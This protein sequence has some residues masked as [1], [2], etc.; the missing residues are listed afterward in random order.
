[1]EIKTLTH[2]A[3]KWTRV[4]PGRSEDY[5]QGISN[6]RRDWATEAAA[7]AQNWKEGLDK[8]ASQGLYGKGIQRAGSSKWKDKSLKKGPQRFSEGV[9]LAGGDY[10]KAL[11]PFHEALA[12]T[13]LG[14]RFPRRDP[15][16]LARVKTV[17]DALVLAKTGQ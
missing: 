17:V 12:R 6:P 15:R 7:G 11:A 10:Q 1:M 2:I 14:P 4:T 8:A 13:D 5:K 9:Y 3:D 16:N